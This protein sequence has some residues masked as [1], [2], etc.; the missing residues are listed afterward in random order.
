[1]FLFIGDESVTEEEIAIE[2]TEIDGLSTTD[3]DS[4]EDYDD[5]EYKKKSQVKFS[6]SPIKVSSCNFHIFPRNRKN[7]KPGLVFQE[8]FQ[9]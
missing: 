1:M 8:I 7:V 9:Y 2:Y 4:D 5:Y 3:E 6:R